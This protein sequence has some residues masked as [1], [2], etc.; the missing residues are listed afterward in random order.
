MSPPPCTHFDIC[1]LPSDTQ[2]DGKSFCWLHSPRQN[3]PADHFDRVLHQLIA[4]A[5]TDFRN[6]VAPA[7]KDIPFEGVNFQHPLDLSGSLFPGAI[8]RIR[9]C[10]LRQGLSLRVE[11]EFGGG[12]LIVENCEIDGPV[13]VDIHTGISQVAVVHSRVLKGARIRIGTHLQTLTFVGSHLT[14]HLIIRAQ[15]DQCLFVGAAIYG[16]VDLRE[17][18]LRFPLQFDQTSWGPHSVLDLSSSTLNRG[19][20]LNATVQPPSVVRL[21]G[22]RIQGDVSIAADFTKPRIDVQAPTSRPVIAGEGRFSR[23]SFE[24][25]LLVGNNLSNMAFSDVSWPTWRRRTVLF[26]EI[27]VRR[28]IGPPLTWV[29]EAYEVLKQYYQLRGSHRVAGEFHYG[30]LEM[31]RHEYGNIRS[32]VCWEFLYWLLSGYGTRPGRAF[33]SLAL[34]VLAGAV[35]SWMAGVENPWE[36]LRLSLA[37]S[38]LQRPDTSRFPGAGVSWIAVF[39][40]IAGAVLIALLVLA[41]RM[42]VKR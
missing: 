17:C 34:A 28:G 6:I 22:C 23:V 19:L 13:L 42:R 26:D 18:E 16:N 39:Q 11:R 37:V 10:R 24:R 41:V 14:E 8:L 30:E 12:G 32:V 20:E 29:R 7:G 5:H 1:R 31:R 9:Q 4:Q 35:G 40:A 27:A 36:A 2:E 15:L 38:T 25:C 21:N 33:F 3:K